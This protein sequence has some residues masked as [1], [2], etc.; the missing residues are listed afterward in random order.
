MLDT[1]RKYKIPKVIKYAGAWWGYNA[2]IIRA[3]IS[4]NTGAPINGRW[5]AVKGLDCSF[6]NSLIASANGMGKPIRIGLL[7]PFRV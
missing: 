4:L 2:Q 5:F 6:T 7:G 3:N 1:H